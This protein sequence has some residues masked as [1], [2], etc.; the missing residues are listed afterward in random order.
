MRFTVSPTPK[1]VAALF[2]LAALGG[3]YGAHLIKE[4][5]YPFTRAGRQ[6]EAMVHATQKSCPNQDATYEKRLRSVLR[7]TPDFTIELLNLN[8]VRICLDR[9]MNEVT[10]RLMG[11]FYR[12]SRTLVLR[13]DG[14]THSFW[15]R[16]TTP[17]ERG[18]MPEV[19]ASVLG[20]RDDF[21]DV[22]EPMLYASS[23]GEVPKRIEWWTMSTPVAAKMKPLRI[24]R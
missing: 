6:L 2:A 19:V 11:V 10:N 18:H 5:I 4:T 22:K 21:A 23:I 13:D 3:A 1:R 20:A 16:I 7:A 15:K 24:Q 17:F 12:N 9:R 14:R 8:G